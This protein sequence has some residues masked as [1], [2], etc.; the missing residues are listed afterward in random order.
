MLKPYWVSEEKGVAWLLLALL[1]VCLLC[2]VAVGI[3]VNYFY[4]FFYDELQASDTHKMINSFYYFVAVRALFT[5]AV[6][7]SAYINGTL[8]IRWQRWLTKHYLNR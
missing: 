8:S 1:T 7:A 4:K 6:T 3:G 2:E 5:A